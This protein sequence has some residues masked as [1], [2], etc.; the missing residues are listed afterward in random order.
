MES[1]KILVVED[2][3][4]IAMHI[5]CILEEND[6]EVTTCISY[7]EAIKIIDSWIPSLVL[8][9]INLNKAKDGVDIGKYLLHNDTIPYIYI[10]SYSDKETLDRVNETR[11]YGYLVKPFK[12]IDVITAI[13]VVLNNY[14]HRAIDSSRT[15]SIDEVAIPYKLRQVIDYINEN[16]YK[17]IEIDELVAMTQWKRHHFIKL[18]SKYLNVSPYQYIL[19]RKID[20]SKALLEEST[21]PLNEIAYEVGFN[22]YSNFYNAFKKNC[23]ITPEQYRKKNQK[24]L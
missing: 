14:K 19:T 1:L 3:A 13:S 15:E 21:I 12:G 8:V 22:S 9:D 6:Y 10:T 16:I 24:L 17:Q 2:E 5:K 23:K 20:K 4:L 18:F 7:E 11:P